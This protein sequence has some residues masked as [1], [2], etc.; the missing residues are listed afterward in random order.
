MSIIE[1]SVSKLRP[2][3]LKHLT[4][5]W[6]VLPFANCIQWISVRMFF[7]RSIVMVDVMCV[8]FVQWIDRVPVFLREFVIWSDRDW[9]FFVWDGVFFSWTIPS[10]TLSF[11][12]CQWQNI[13]LS[14][15]SFTK[16]LFRSIIYK[17]QNV[18]CVRENARSWDEGF[19]L[20]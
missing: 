15:Q 9:F 2:V 3:E 6:P 19:V 14:P 10:Y 17:S 13:T 11:L 5:E 8:F 12:K 20:L 16:W 1:H 4:C 18:R 7:V